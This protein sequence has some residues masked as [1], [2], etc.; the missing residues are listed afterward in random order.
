MLT[1][2]SNDF[3]QALEAVKFELELRRCSQRTVY[4]YERH[5]IKF[6]QATPK[7]FSQ[8]TEQDIRLYLYE[9]VR[10]GL[11]SDYINQVRA[12]LRIF[13]RVGLRQDLDD[14]MLPRVRKKTVR[15]AVLSQEEIKLILSHIK[16]PR[17]RVILFACYSSGLRIGEALNLQVK[18]IDS[19][20]M[21]IFVRQSKNLKDR[22]TLL[23]PQCLNVLRR[24]WKLYRPE[25]QYLFPGTSPEK[26]MA[27][28]G[29]Q[30]AFHKAVIISEIHKDAS[31][32]TLRH[33]FA[34]H[35]YEAGTPLLTIQ[36]LLGHAD[37]H[38]TCL[39]THL[40]RKHLQGVESPADSFGGDFNVL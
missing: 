7:P 23:S 20:N 26:P 15:P 19:K 8:L 3:S 28:Q 1:Q 33:C 18:D 13:F 21:Q 39:Y 27:R 12:A 36:V 5:I 25:G 37:I 32:H 35:L 30:S 4:L 34:T 22:Y 17:Y 6:T 38:T 10:R 40:S 9:L 29:I 14:S 11:G 31:I 2:L 24:Y 16:N